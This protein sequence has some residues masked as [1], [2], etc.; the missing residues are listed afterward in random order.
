M[1][2]GPTDR[3]RSVASVAESGVCAA[4]IVGASESSA[5]TSR[6]ACTKEVGIRVE[7]DVGETTK[8]PDLQFGENLRFDLFE[9]GVVE[10]AALQH[11][12]GALQTCGR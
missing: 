11:L 9:L 10:E 7:D 5:V 2:T 3:Q 1:F 4:S 12:L 8:Q 6:R